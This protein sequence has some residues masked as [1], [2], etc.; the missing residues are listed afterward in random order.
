MKVKVI[1]DFG[2]FTR[3]GLLADL[4]RLAEIWGVGDISQ[5]EQEGRG[6][7]G[8]GRRQKDHRHACSERVRD[9]MT[10]PHYG[11]YQ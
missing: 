1:L 3:K 6:Q 11:R 9:P 4:E 8:D 7:R 2:S 10:L 5:T